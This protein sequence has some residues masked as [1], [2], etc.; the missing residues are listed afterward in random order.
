[1][2]ALFFPEASVNFYMATYR[3]LTEECTVQEMVYS[4]YFER[5][6]GH[7]RTRSE[8]RLKPFYLKI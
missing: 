1:M 6:D 7:R 2:E 4:K 5:T 3:Y 8:S